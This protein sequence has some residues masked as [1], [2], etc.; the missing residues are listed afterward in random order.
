MT[1]YAFG[2]GTVHQ[3]IANGHL[4]RRLYVTDPRVDPDAQLDNMCEFNGETE[5]ESTHYREGFVMA[6][7]TVQWMNWESC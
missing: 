1:Y 5:E 4:I 2:T 6:D 7:G 3:S